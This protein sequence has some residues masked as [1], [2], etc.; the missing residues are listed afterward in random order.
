MGNEHGTDEIS[1][2]TQNRDNGC[3]CDCAWVCWGRGFSH[4]TP[5]IALGRPRSLEPAAVLDLADIM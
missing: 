4:K 1:W 5:G 3:E 2:E